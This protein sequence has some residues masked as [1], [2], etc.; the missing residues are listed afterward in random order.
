MRVNSPDAEKKRRE[1]LLKKFAPISELVDKVDVS[2]TPDLKNAAHF[3][4]RDGSVLTLDE[5]GA[6]DYLKLIDD[7][8][9]EFNKNDDLS[10]RSVERFTHDAIFRLL[11]ARSNSSAE[12]E[13]ERIEAFT[14]LKARL[15]AEPT[16]YKCF[17]PVEGFAVQDLPLSFGCICF[18][19]LGRGLS[20][21]NHVLGHRGLGD[22]D[23]DLS[24]L[25]V[26]TR[27]PQTG[28][29]CSS[30]GSV[31]VPRERWVDGAAD[32]SGSSM[33]NSV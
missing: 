26:Y 32:V 14:E 23:S 11:G 20:M 3:T 18:D 24:Q 2:A 13:T 8:E 27:S 6:R 1:R 28:L 29:P 33:S 25:A 5:E 21:P 9:R 30:S 15:S 17:V 31:R 16:K 4:L 19:E 7:L 12:F 22:V 10:R